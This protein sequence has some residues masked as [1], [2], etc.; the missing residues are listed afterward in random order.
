ME[1]GTL[2][3]TQR[4]T[5]EIDVDELQRAKQNLRTSTNR[6][7]VDK[8]LREVNRMHALRRAADLIRAGGLNVVRPEE[9]PELR[10]SR[11]GE[12]P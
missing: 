3:R 7:T 10:R 9:V 2:A 11:V 5:L 6:E 12:A 4:T 8:A 1:R